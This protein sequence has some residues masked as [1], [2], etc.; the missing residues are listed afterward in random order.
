[1]RPRRL[2]RIVE[3]VGGAGHVTVAEVCAALEVSPATARRDLDALAEQRLVR[4]TYGGASALVPLGG[5]SPPGGR[6]EGESGARLA[7]RATALV[8]PGSTVGLGGGA[9][10]VAVARALAVADGVVVGAGGGLTVVTDA[11]DVAYELAARPH[12]HVVVTG[13]SVRPRSLR[14]VGPAA[15]AAVR[16]VVLDVAILGVD[17]VHPRF[18]TTTADADEAQVGRA[19]AAA[20]HRVVVVAGGGAHG[21]TGP[22]RLLPLDEVDVLVTDAAPAGPL[23]EALAASG[24]EVLLA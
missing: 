23:A 11:L 13:G 9:V 20:A 14:L 17:G 1:M 16:E 5:G 10:T 4:R 18:G 21:V 15:V 2:S 12:V 22:Q 24:V 3:M 8:P 7:R 19:L 6:A